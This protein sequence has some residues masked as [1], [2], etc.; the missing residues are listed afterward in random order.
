[1]IQAKKKISSQ[2]Q[3]YGEITLK[4]IRKDGT[5]RNQRTVPMHSLVRNY[6]DIIWYGFNAQSG[7]DIP[8]WNGTN[9]FWRFGY[10]ARINMVAGADY[11]GIAVGSSNTALAFDDIKPNT[12]IPH[13]TGVGELKYQS[14]NV[15]LENDD[16]RVALTRTFDNQSGGQV[17]V[18]ELALSVQDG[19]DSDTA[20]TNPVM[21]ARD[22]LDSAFTVLDTEILSVDY[23]FEIVGGVRNSKIMAG[24]FTLGQNGSLTY[25]HIG[26]GTTS[27]DAQDMFR[28]EPWAYKGNDPRQGVSLGTGDTAV[29]QND[30]DLESF[31]PLSSIDKRTQN[32]SRNV[33]VGAGT[34]EIIVE[35]DVENISGSDI[36]IREMGLYF[37]DFS[38]NPFMV[39]RFVLPSPTDLVDG[40]VRTVRIVLSYSL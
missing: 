5:V 11:R 21:L 24:S 40:T 29:T 9:E 4:A 15:T 28:A 36:T 7:F 31:V 23:S 25:Y 35:G 14:G 2:L 20:S 19:S 12:L 22:V 33:D 13:G 10:G 18:W 30:T 32:L 34:Y 1:M 39:N 16:K 8:R 3:P 38:D 6:W 26:G 37:L 17:D 27:K